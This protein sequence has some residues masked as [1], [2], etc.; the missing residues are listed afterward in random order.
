MSTDRRGIHT[1]TVLRQSAHG[2]VS[3]QAWACRQPQ[4]GAAAHAHDGTGGD[5]AGAEY[6][7]QASAAQGVSVSAAW[8]GRREAKSGVE[9][10]CDLYPPGTWLC[11]SG[12]GDRLVLA[13]RAVVADIEQHGCVVL[14]GLFRRCV[15]SARQAG[16]VQQRSG[17]AIHE[18]RLH[19]RAQAGKDCDQHGWARAGAGQHLRRTVVAQCQ[20]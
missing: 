15:A 11:L 4:A 19:G 6:E 14:R 5:G 2:G 16:D 13:A 18:Q 17:I 8:C 20:V 10:G 12:G 9:Y 3:G 1:T 7:R